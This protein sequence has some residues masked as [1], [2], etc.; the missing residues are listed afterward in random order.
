MI[1]FR[2]MRQLWYFCAVAEESH[3][4][5]AAE[6]LGI[7]QPPL[8]Q[9]I[10]VLE[11]SLKL[12]LFDRSRRRTTLTPDGAAMLPAVQRFMAQARRLE[13][14][15]EE[16]RRGRLQQLDI[17]AVTSVIMH[18]LPQVIADLRREF[19]DA[20]ITLRE[21]SSGG[22]LAALREGE[23][24]LAIGRFD[25]AETG[26]EVRELV[27]DELVVALAPSHPLAERRTV[28][29]TDLRDEHW[30]SFP[31]YTSPPFYDTILVACRRH[32]FSPRMSHEVSSQLSQIAFVVCGYGIA[33]IPR[34]LARLYPRGVAFIRLEEPIEVVTAAAAW[35]GETPLIRRLIELAAGRRMN[36]PMLA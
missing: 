36:S 28:A 11:Q 35:T 2:L 29:L 17:G 18:L 8:T 1:D 26:V 9:Q 16:V 27:S 19:P 6:R 32:G 22:A 33:L 14:V 30:I 15:V 25:G 3:F 20:A 12:K 7:S 13:E 23:I 31:R 4:R 34:E 5:R 24:Q 10:Q 21:M